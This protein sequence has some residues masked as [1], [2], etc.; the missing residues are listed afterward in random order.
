MVRPDDVRSSLP[1]HPVP[2][3]P[4]TLPLVR[5]DGLVNRVLDLRPA[6]LLALPQQE[7]V[8]DFTCVEGWTVPHVSWQGV[9]LR[10]VL[11]LAGVRAE[12]HWLQASAG[13]FSVPLP[14]EVWETAFLALRLGDEDLSVEHGGPVRLVVPGQ[15][16]FTSV[17]WLDHLEVR[18][19]A[20]PNTAEEIALGRMA[21]RAAIR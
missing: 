19:A 11:D 2:H 21:S 12:A 13:L 10:E 1:V 8:G 14:D 3:R 6:D 20:G 16:C 15:A 17:K 5:V 18:A 9:P 7:V 4:T